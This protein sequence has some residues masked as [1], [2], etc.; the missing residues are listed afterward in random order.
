[1]TRNRALLR[2]ASPLIAAAVLAAAAGCG[3]VDPADASDPEAAQ[4]LASSQQAAAPS[5]AAAPPAAPSPAAEPTPLGEPTAAPRVVLRPDGLGFTDGGSSSSSLPFGTGAA[6]V[7]AATDRALLAGGLIP[8]PDCGPGSTTV[9]HEGLF[10]QLRDDAFVGWSTGSPGLTT[11]D[12]IGVGSTLADLSTS[13]GALSVSATTL[14]VEG[15]TGAG[16]VAGFLDG[17]SSDS[18]VIGMAAGDRCLA[19]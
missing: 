16:G 10:L 11:G 18:V 6:T 2:T 13:F 15:T 14:G 7:R 1:M 12:G 5:A 3:T 19:R 17:T 4:T 9:Q 8:T